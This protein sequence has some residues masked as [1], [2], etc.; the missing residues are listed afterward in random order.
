MS[1]G[2]RRPACLHF[3]VPFQRFAMKFLHNPRPAHA[4]RAEI[5]AALSL[6]L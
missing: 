4:I 5:L 1:R 2:A 6:L 3:C